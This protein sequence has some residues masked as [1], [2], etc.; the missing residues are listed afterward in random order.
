M[1]TS[2]DFWGQRSRFGADGMGD[3]FSRWPLILVELVCPIQ[4][5]TSRYFFDRITFRLMA[6][7]DIPGIFASTTTSFREAGL[8]AQEITSDDA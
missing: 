1:Y 7:L 3:F 5:Q 6:C 2:P 4:I 8:Y